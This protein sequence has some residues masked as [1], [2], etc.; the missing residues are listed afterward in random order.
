[1]YYRPILCRGEFSA[2]PRTISVLIALSRN[3]LSLQHHAGSAN[4]PSDFASQN[5]SAWK[6][7]FCVICSFILETENSVVILNVF[8]EDILESGRLLLLTIR[9]DLCCI[10][11]HLKRPLSIRRKAVSEHRF[12]F[13]RWLVLQR[14][15]LLSPPLNWS[16]SKFHNPSKHR[17][18]L[19]VRFLPDLCL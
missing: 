12:D 19:R 18:H 5:T 1:M 14:Q 8:V 17:H 13:Y 4:L 15:Q 7:P 3:Q 16:Q 2:G 9:P 6:V 11:A 10:C